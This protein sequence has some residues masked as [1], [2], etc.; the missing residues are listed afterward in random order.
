MNGVATINL[1][2]IMNIDKYF[3]KL[4]LDKKCINLKIMQNIFPSIITISEKYSYK[5]CVM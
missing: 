5:P 1:N 4:S 2:Y 3:G